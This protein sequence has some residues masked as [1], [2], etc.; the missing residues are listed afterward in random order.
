MDPLAQLKDIHLAEPI[1]N[2]PPAY[3]WWLLIALGLALSVSLLLWVVKR[4]KRRKARKQA[5]VILSQLD[6]SQSWQLQLNQVLKRLVISYYPGTRAASL[7]GDDWVAF[8]ASLLPHKQQ[9]DFNQQMLA[10]QQSLYDHNAPHVDFSACKQ[11]VLNWIKVATPPGRK[12]QESAKH[13]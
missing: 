13:V 8:L 9:S 5:L 7:Y 10:L 2:W 6:E 4:L 11:Q 1:G 3:G 12:Q